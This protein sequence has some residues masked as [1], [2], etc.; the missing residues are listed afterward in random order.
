LL[1]ALSSQ[2]EKRSSVN[3]S[4]LPSKVPVSMRCVIIVVNFPWDPNVTGMVVKGKGLR[5]VKVRTGSLMEGG[6]AVYFCFRP[7]TAGSEI[8]RH[9]NPGFRVLH[10]PGFY[11]VHRPTPPLPLWIPGWKSAVL[12]M[13]NRRLPGQYGDGGSDGVQTIPPAGTGVA[14]KVP[15]RSARY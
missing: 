10:V 8:C 5:A 14:G 7:G 1:P 11:R 12:P 15:A 13:E 2:P 3:P 4:A 9:K 6:R